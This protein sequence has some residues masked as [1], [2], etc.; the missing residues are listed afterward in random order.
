MPIIVIVMM[1]IVVVR[2]ITAIAD[3]TRQL[4]SMPHPHRQN[5]RCGRMIAGQTWAKCLAHT[6]HEYHRRSERCSY[7]AWVG[8]WL[9]R[10]AGT[11]AI[12]RWIALR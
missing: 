4:S 11:N 10:D 3:F 5:R 8:G 2:A 9:G 1:I 7:R 6:A 12:N